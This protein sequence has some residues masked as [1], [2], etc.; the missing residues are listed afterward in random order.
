MA[1]TE[2]KEKQISSPQINSYFSFIL[3]HIF[4]LSFELQ[5]IVYW[6][7]AEK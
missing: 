4:E 7:T 1:K 3:L 6:T 5:N 2:N